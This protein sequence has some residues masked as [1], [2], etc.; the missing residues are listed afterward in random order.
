M[1]FLVKLLSSIFFTGHLPRGSGTAASMVACT[2]WVFFSDRPIYPV[3]SLSVVLLGF[4]ICGYAERVV[5]REKD[6]PKIV[7]DEAAGMLITYVTFRFSWSHEGVVY[8]A[9]GFLF[10]RILDILKPIPISSMQKIRG[11]PGIMLDDVTS[12]IVANGLLQ[13]VRLIFFM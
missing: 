7:I 8:L 2:F 12:G 5:F 11:G 9:S 13:L 10:F 1:K 3:I 6:S 4:F